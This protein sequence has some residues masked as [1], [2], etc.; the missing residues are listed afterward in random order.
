MEK[1]LSA[2]LMIRGKH[3]NFLLDPIQNTAIIRDRMLR[4]KMG[5]TLARIRQKSL[6]TG[7]VG[8]NMMVWD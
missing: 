7:I 3:E 6:G 2:E 4:S 1:S 5:D 8:E